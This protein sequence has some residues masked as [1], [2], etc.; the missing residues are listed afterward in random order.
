MKVAQS[1]PQIVRCNNWTSPVDVSEWIA[2]RR[3]FLETDR[4]LRVSDVEALKGPMSFST[5]LYLK[6]VKSCSYLA[7]FHVLNRLSWL[8]VETTAVQ[9]SLR[10]RGLFPH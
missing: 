6:I 10:S 9:S 2:I 7:F 5:P 8:P 4:L 1:W 3:Y